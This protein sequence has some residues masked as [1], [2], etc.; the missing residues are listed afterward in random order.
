MQAAVRGWRVRAEV[1][2]AKLARQSTAQRDAGVFPE[3]EEAEL[4]LFA[5]RAAE[6]FTTAPRPATAWNNAAQPSALGGESLRSWDQPCSGLDLA[7]LEREHQDIEPA[8]RDIFEHL[9]TAAILRH[10]GEPTLGVVQPETVA[11]ERS[12]DGNL[13]ELWRMCGLD[14]A[15]DDI[16][17]CRP[18]TAADPSRGLMVKLQLLDPPDPVHVVCD[19]QVQLRTALAACDELATSLTEEAQSGVLADTS[20]E[21]T[22]QAD[23][24]VNRESQADSQNMSAQSSRVSSLSGGSASDRSALG[25]H[26]E[27]AAA[28]M[29]ACDGD[30]QASSHPADDGVLQH[31]GFSDHQLPLTRK[32][33]L[34]QVQ[35]TP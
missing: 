23:R 12:E 29:S 22:T 25:G 34:R 26:A 2:R 17:S 15:E 6:F 5:D 28:N 1:R 30:T 13:E 31:T 9:A 33:Q 20:T 10:Q 16:S 3:D 18:S 35:S 4:L 14:L 7:S 21:L 32:E 19:R 8:Y 11:R 27:W 24:S